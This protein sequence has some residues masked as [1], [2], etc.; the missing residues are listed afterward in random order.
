MNVVLGKINN[1][2]GPKASDFFVCDTISSKLF[3][4]PTRF[5]DFCLFFLL[6]IFDLFF[7]VLSLHV[8][9]LYVILSYTQISVRKESFVIRTVCTSIHQDIAKSWWVKTKN[10]SIAFGCLCVHYSCS[11][12][13]IE[14][15]IEIAKLR[16][17]KYTHTNTK[18]HT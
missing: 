1:R 7:S 8:K 6:M 5:W 2:K 11:L 18:Q 12:P 15:E 4:L 9:I 3:L 17:Y 14:I 16:L 13:E 10:R